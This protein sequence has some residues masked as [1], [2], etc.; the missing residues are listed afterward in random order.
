GKREPVAPVETSF[1][2]GLESFEIYFFDGVDWL[3]L[4]GISELVPQTVGI[5]VRFV[6]D[7][8]KNN[9]RQEFIESAFILPNET[10]KNE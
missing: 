5:S 4:T 8:D 6:F 9:E 3:R 10:F 1:L 7:S 2:S